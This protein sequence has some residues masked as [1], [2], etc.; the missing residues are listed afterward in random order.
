MGL[1]APIMLADSILHH[2]PETPD[3]FSAQLGAFLNQ[4]GLTGFVTGVG[5]RALSELLAAAPKIRRTIGEGTQAEDSGCAPRTAASNI[6]LCI[7][8]RANEDSNPSPVA[9]DLAVSNN[10]EDLGR[11]RIE[12]DVLGKDEILSHESASNTRGW[13][14]KPLAW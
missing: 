10:G 11:V 12:N 4:V 6:L 3:E 9:P 7:N 5:Q 1:E 8:V 13:R 2:E 14:A